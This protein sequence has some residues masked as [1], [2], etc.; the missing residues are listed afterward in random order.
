[1]SDIDFKTILDKG[2]DDTIVNSRGNSGQTIIHHI[3]KEGNDKLLIELLERV[4]R[5]L[6]EKLLRSYLN[7]QDRD[8]NTAMHIA[9]NNG[10]D[11][12]ASILELY[13]ANRKIE[14]KHHISFATESPS[15]T[16]S[17]SF[18]IGSNDFNDIVRDNSAKDD[19]VQCGNT[20]AITKLFNNI[21]RATGSE[22]N[23]PF[24]LVGGSSI[25]DDEIHE[26]RKY[27]EMNGGA[28]KA[29]TVAKKASTKKTAT[30]KESAKKTSTKKSSTKKDKEE[31]NTTSD[32][33]K[34]TSDIHNDVIQLIR[35]MG[36]SEEDTIALKAG[37]YRYTKDQHPELNG[38]DRALKMKSYV[39]KK[40]L[41]MIDVEAVKNAIRIGRENKQKQK[42]EMAKENTETSQ[43]QDS[44]DF[45]DL[46][47]S[48]Y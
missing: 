41:N 45:K 43:F 33:N 22:D 18:N 9:V 36:Y 24:N 40:Y 10:Y 12:I 6:N 20:S 26:F 3:C 7:T 37:L 48:S 19:S 17:S 15:N 11:V 29:K 5:A 14:N 38:R 42:N 4:R 39:K 21:T 13:G 16:D 31:E 35:D 8:G 47:D 27:I 44:S 1:M 30:K 25:S 32:N 28:A 23:K 34:S 46:S 2:D